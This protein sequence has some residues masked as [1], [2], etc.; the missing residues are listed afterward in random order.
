M[1]LVSQKFYHIE[2]V[3]AIDKKFHHHQTFTT[4]IK[5]LG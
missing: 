5:P 4:K 2:I 1:I 3:F